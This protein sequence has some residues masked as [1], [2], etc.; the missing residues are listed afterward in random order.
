MEISRGKLKKLIQEEISRI[1]T[2]QENTAG[3]QMADVLKEEYSKLST[4]DQQIFLENF[5]SYINKIM[6]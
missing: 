5:V 3:Y 6:S 1:T 2:E 4:T